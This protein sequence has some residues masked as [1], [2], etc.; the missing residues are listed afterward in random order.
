MPRAISQRTSERII[1][2]D[3]RSYLSLARE[4]A[5]AG[6]SVLVVGKLRVVEIDPFVAWLARRS[7]PARPAP[8]ANDE[9]DALSELAADLGVV[10]EPSRRRAR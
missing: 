5:A 3:R 4:Y 10:L 1:G 9:T 6:G 7:Q 2:V 8:A